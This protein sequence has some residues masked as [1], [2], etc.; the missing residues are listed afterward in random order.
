[1]VKSSVQKIIHFLKRGTNVIRLITMVIYCNTI[2]LLWSPVMGFP[3]VGRIFTQRNL[4]AT[5]KLRAG[6]HLTDAYFCTCALLPW[7]LV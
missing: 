5:V 6:I 2:S 3:I 1:M 4:N 7:L